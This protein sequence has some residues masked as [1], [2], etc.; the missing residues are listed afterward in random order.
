M[1]IIKLNFG[2]ANNDEI[3]GLNNAETWKMYYH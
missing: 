3:V 1:I 2:I